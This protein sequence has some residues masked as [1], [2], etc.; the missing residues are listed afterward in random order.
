MSDVY[1]FL[2]D[3]VSHLNNGTLSSAIPPAS[4]FRNMRMHRQY[5]EYLIMRTQPCGSLRNISPSLLPSGVRG[6]AE[7]FLYSSD[8]NMFMFAVTWKGLYLLPRDWIRHWM[9][10]TGRL[11]RA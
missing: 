3:L 11:P 10:T 6:Q 4:L 1:K 2:E 5:V 7:Y 8:E 9:S